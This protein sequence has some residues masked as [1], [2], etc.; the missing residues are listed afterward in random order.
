MVLHAR[1]ETNDNSVSIVTTRS[2]GRCDIDPEPSIQ[3]TIDKRPFDLKA[4]ERAA[5]LL[6][7]TV[8]IAPFRLP[9]ADVW[10]IDVPG[11]A[12]EAQLTLT[13]WPSIKRVD[14]RSSHV[15]VVVT[16]IEQIEL[17]E[18]VEVVFRRS[19]GEYLIVPIG[20]KV[21]VRA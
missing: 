19:N 15:M 1:K 16:E 13:F 5:S 7:G 21:I 10:Q 9:D 8:R 11:P 18:G 3:R 20:G 6:G 12:D 4:I 17:V 2:S 14:A